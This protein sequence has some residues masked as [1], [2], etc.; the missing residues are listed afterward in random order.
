[1][2]LPG[3]VIGKLFPYSLPVRGCDGLLKG[4][5][6]YTTTRG[7]L[8]IHRVTKKEVA[9]PW[10]KKYIYTLISLREREHH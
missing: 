6:S 1:M 7:T 8:T 2:G 5:P 4:N 3:K 10:N 9:L